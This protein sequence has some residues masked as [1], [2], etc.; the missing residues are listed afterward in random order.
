MK[1]ITNEFNNFFTP[2][3]ALLIYQQEGERDNNRYSDKDV[4]VESYDI[5]N[6][7]KPINAHPLSSKEMLHLSELFQSAKDL[8]QGY[9]NSEGL[10]PAKVL[11]IHHGG[12]GSVVWFTPAQEQPVFFA[13]ILEIP[14]GTAKVP[15]MLWK[16]DDEQLSVYALRTNRKPSLQT[17]LYHAPF[18]NIYENGNVCMGTV[19]IQI[20]K[21]CSLEDFMQQ[22]ENYF[23]NSYFSHLMQDFNPVTTNIVQLWQSQVESHADFPVDV[24]KKTNLTIENILP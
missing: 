24:L 13:G 17:T 22:W 14:S 4:Y 11:H 5:G 8:Q 21:N 3:K 10:L 6:N 1:N 18:F 2:V 9:L 19:D 7:G 20:A 15:P 23:W 12:K 16:A